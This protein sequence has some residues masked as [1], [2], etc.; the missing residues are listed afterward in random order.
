[1]PIYYWPDSQICAECIHGGPVLSDYDEPC[2]YACAMDCEE[3]DGSFCPC[4]EPRPD[5]DESELED[6]AGMYGIP[7]NDED[8]DKAEE[9]AP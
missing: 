2:A 9:K 1:M 4:F 7:P 5:T 8:V 3:N 6:F